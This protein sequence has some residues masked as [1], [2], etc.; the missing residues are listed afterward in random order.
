VDVHEDEKCPNETRS[1]ISSTTGGVMTEEVGAVTGEL[2]VAT[3]PRS[4]TI[5][6]AVRYAGADEW[7]A[8]EGGPIVVNNADELSYSELHEHIVR[9]LTT[10]GM[11]VKGNEEPTSLRGFS[12]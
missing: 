4:G 6:V 9:C 2:E 5:E 8:V 3:R 1:T 11:V 7:Y 10:P 12:P